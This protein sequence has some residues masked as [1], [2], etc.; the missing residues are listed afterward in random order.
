MSAAESE[1]YSYKARLRADR[2]MLLNF[3]AEINETLKN[4]GDINDV[5]CD[6]M[7]I[8]NK[9]HQPLLDFVI[10]LKRR[11][12]CDEDKDIVN[13]TFFDW[14]YADELDEY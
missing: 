4:H 13:D 6:W 1:Q 5:F 9:E 10:E 11:L 2:F 7:F 12:H 8:P 3:F 14:V